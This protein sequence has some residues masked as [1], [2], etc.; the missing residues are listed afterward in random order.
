MGA[1]LSSVSSVSH[2]PSLS[3]IESL[4]LPHLLPSTLSLLLLSLYLAFYLLLLPVS[5]KTFPFLSLICYFTRSFPGNQVLYY[6]LRAVSCFP[7]CRSNSPCST[8]SRFCLS[9]SSSHCSLS[10]F[11]CKP[12]A[13]RSSQFENL[14]T[15]STLLSGSQ[16]KSSTDT[17]ALGSYCRNACTVM[18]DIFSF[19]LKCR[20]ASS[21]RLMAPSTTSLL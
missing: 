14:A 15:D 1:P 5:L 21:M 9:Y 13:V 4:S 18:R 3:A 11:A 17:L 6:W 16:K 19:F 7:L 2:A 10:S 12:V 20:A 8:P